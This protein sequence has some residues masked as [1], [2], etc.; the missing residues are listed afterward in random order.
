MAR[1]SG[2]TTRRTLVLGSIVWAGLPAAGRA[3]PSA[4][5]VAFERFYKSF[6]VLGLQFSDELSAL[7]GRNVALRGYMAPPLKPESDFFVLTREPLAICPFCQSDADWPL[8]IAVVYLTR[9]AGLSPAGARL[10]VTGRLELGSWTDPRTG[11]V[12]QI[13]LVDASLGA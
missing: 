7:S 2:A 1:Q 5:P 11:F 10:T 3:A 8:D 12:S 6:G 9:A 4:Q 13:R